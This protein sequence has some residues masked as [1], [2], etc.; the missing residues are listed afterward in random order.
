VELD[1]SLSNRI[2]FTFLIVFL[3]FIA[4]FWLCH[5]IFSLLDFKYAI[6]FSILLIAISSYFL[7]TYLLTPSISTNSSLDK[8]IKDTLHELNAP[9]ATIKANTQLLKQKPQN[10]LDLKRLLRIER[11]CEN[12]YELY[13]Q[14]E[15]FIKKEIYLIDEELFDAAIIV[16]N[17]IAKSQELQGDI[18]LKSELDS[19]LV[20]ADKRGFEQ[21]VMNLLSNAYKYNF[22]NGSVNIVLKDECLV[23]EDSGIGMDEHTTL[24]IFD[25]YYQNDPK[26][27]GFGIGLHKVREF[28]EKYGIF[29]GI[30][31]KINRGTKVSLKLSGISFN[32]KKM[33]YN[34]KFKERVK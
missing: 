13:E 19:L 11:S 9:L 1:I 7:S 27:D 24:R 4:I 15:Y 22:K 31:S 21:V 20:Y 32:N 29:I 8:L 23:V 33:R 12:L 3:T 26:K 25:R 17:A 5:Y 28:C 34:D 18:L 30:S 6:S 2:F 16:K 10:N 14:V